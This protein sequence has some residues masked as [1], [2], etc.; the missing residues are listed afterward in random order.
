[1][2]SARAVRLVRVAPHAIMLHARDQEHPARA[3]VPRA[4]T[5]HARV[6]AHGQRPQPLHLVQE[7]HL[8]ILR[9]R[10]AI[11]MAA[12]RPTRSGKAAVH[13]QEA[14]PLMAAVH[15]QR[16]GMVG[17]RQ[18]RVLVDSTAARATGAEDVPAR[19]SALTN[20]A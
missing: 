11:A 1:M 3:P 16:P 13:D 19:R 10:A 12:A 15:D 4:I 17:P 9:V 6:A 18:A 14:L 2:L 7:A 5:L 8:L 20:G